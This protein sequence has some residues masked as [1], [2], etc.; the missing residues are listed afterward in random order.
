MLC[1]YLLTAFF[2]L[3]TSLLSPPLFAS[4]DGCT[5]RLFDNTVARN[6]AGSVQVDVGSVAVDV[7][8]VSSKNSLDSPPQSL[9][10]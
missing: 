2:L 6:A 10:V 7:Q 8:E 1:S 9:T 5:A 3:I 4:Q